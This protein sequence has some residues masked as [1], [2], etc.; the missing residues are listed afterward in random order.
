MDSQIKQMLI[1]GAASALV[2][3]VTVLLTTEVSVAVK[4]RA[5]AKAVK[6]QSED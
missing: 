2:S 5:T 1:V 4:K 3:V 6:E